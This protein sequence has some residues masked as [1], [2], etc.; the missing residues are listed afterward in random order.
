MGLSTAHIHYESVCQRIDWL[1][2]VFVE[3]VAAAELAAVATTPGEHHSVLVDRRSMVVAKCKFCDLMILELVHLAR[4]RLLE[5]ICI[6]EPAE[7]AVAPCVDNAVSR[8]RP[9][10]VVPG[11]D[12][13]WH[14]SI[15]I[16]L[17]RARVELMWNFDVEAASIGAR[18]SAF[19]II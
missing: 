11:L 10:V 12:L 1:H 16:R 19:I 18:L 14:L 8:H 9:R 17:E 5:N 3:D 7:V 2:G 15:F 4:H 6:A 13:N